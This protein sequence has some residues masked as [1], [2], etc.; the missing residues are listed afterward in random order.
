M[1]GGYAPLSCSAE[2][3]AFQKAWTSDL[4][5]SI[6]SGSRYAFANADTP[7][8]IFHAMG[9]PVVTNQWWSA[10]IAA[11]RLSTHYFDKM[12]EMGFHDRLARYSSLPLIAEL[13][14]DR[15]RQPWGGLP[16]PAILCARQSTEDHQR[17]FDLWAQAT[18]APQFLFSAPGAP[19]PRPDWWVR[20][21]HDWEELFGTDRLD[22]M[23]AEIRA[24]IAEVEELTGGDFDEE[25][26]ALYMAAIHEQETLFEQADVL[27][28]GA[29]RCPIRIAEQIPNVMIPQWHRGSD[30]A[31]SHAHRFHD[32]LA[33]RVDK[34]IAVCAEERVRMMWIGAGLWFDTS[35]YA[36]FEESH[37]AVFAWSMYLPFAADGY[38]RHDKG[39]PL[40]TLAARFSTMNEHLHQP[41]WVNAWLAYQARRYRIDVALMLIPRHDR[42]SGYGSLFAKRALE[43]AGVKVI[44]IWSDMVDPREWDRRAM[45]DH[46]AD[47]LDRHGFGR[48]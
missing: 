24:L 9:M 47:E 42:Y 6:Q 10:V 2:A 32:E 1:N 35:F 39:D 14:G 5:Q 4:R 15:D 40:R 45:Y 29:E 31:I 44:E 7:H 21:R 26:F 41:P 22:L 25:A 8:E 20:A 13:E 34:D 30:W 37:G 43:E 11:K 27:V 12:T 17:I 16:K 28:A 23:V 48:A 33:E 3:G 46:V 18:G 19:H 38:I 36:A